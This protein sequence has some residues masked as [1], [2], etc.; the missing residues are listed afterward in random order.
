MTHSEACHDCTVQAAIW[1]LLCLIQ[2]DVPGLKAEAGAVL[3]LTLPARMLCQP[4]SPFLLLLG[5]PECQLPAVSGL[6]P[7]QTASAG[8]PIPQR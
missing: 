2:L 3:N 4:P 6:S 1:L 7:E 8:Q 5:V